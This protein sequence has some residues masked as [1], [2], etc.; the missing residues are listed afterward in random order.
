MTAEQKQLLEKVKNKLA[1]KEGFKSWTSMEFELNGTSFH[2]MCEKLAIEFSQQENKKNLAELQ[3]AIIDS[4]KDHQTIEQQKQVIK[5]LEENNSVLSETNQSFRKDVA[6]LRAHYKI[7][8]V[9]G[10]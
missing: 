3:Q 2:L 5:I 1:V 4:K 8:S 6:T 9:E 10:G 7:R